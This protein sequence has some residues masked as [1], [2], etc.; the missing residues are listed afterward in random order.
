MNTIVVNKRVETWDIYI[1]RGSPFGNPFEIGK[2]GNRDEVI[3][4]F[5]DYF[6][7]KIAHHEGFRDQVMALAGKRLGCFCKPAACHGDV[8]KEYIDNELKLKQ[9]AKP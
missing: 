1:G 4:Q 6:A 3:E 9:G 2:D 8:I 5:R 7:Y